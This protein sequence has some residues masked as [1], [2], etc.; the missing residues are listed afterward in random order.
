MP[1]QPSK[2][3]PDDNGSKN[4]T[5]GV[6][7]GPLSKQ[8]KIETTVEIEAGHVHTWRN[9]IALSIMV[10]GIIAL[11]I[12]CT[13]T[14][15]VHICIFHPC[16]NIRKPSWTQIINATMTPNLQAEI[17]KSD[18][19]GLTVALGKTNSPIVSGFFCL[20]TET[21]SDEGLPHTLEHLI[22]MGSTTFPYKGVLDLMANRC[23]A[24]RTNA[25]TGS[26]HTC[27]TVST[28]GSNGFMKI[29]PVF[30][31]HIL[32]PTLREG[33]YRTQVHSINGDGQD[34]GVVYGE[35][36]GIENTPERSLLRKTLELLYTETSGYRRETG[37]ILANIRTEATNE[38]VKEYHKKYYRPENLFLTITGKVEEQQIFDALRSVE[39]KWMSK[40][41]PGTPKFQKPWQNL[42]PILPSNE[43]TY[44]YGSTDETSGYVLLAWR[45]S[46]PITGDSKD[47]LAQKYL[48]DFLT[49]PEIG[50]LN[51]AIVSTNEP[52][53]T[54]IEVEQEN[55]REPVFILKFSNV[56]VAN[57]SDIAPQVDVIIKQIIRDTKIFKEI[58]LPMIHS[59]IDQD[60]LR[61]K[62]DKE[63]IPQTFLP[64][65]TCIFQ[66]YGET[67]EDFNNL[68]GRE[69]RVP[70]LRKETTEFWIRALNHSLIHS[71]KIVLRGEPSAK[72]VKE[73][74]KM[75]KKRIEVRNKS[76]N[77]KQ[78]KREEEEG[79]QNQKSPP[80]QVLLEVPL[81]DVNQISFRNVKINNYLTKL[82]T[83]PYDVSI[84]NV[85]SS[86]VQLYI[87]MDTR[88]LTQRQKTML[89]LLLDLWTYAGV[90]KDGSI[91]PQEEVLRNRDRNILGF[92]ADLGLYEEY[93]EAIVFEAQCQLKNLDPALDSIRDTLLFAD[94]TEEEV[95]ISIEN[96][97]HSLPELKQSPSE[98]K[99]AAYN[100][101][102]FKRDSNRYLRTLFKQEPF[103]KNLTKTNHTSTVKD[104][105]E[106]MRTITYSNNGFVYIA[107]EAHKLI[108]DHDG[109]LRKLSNLFK[110]TSSRAKDTSPKIKYD[111]DLMS[112]LS[113]DL[114]HI[115]IGIPETESCYLRRIVDIKG[116]SLTNKEIAEMEVLLRYLS[117]RMY[118]QIRGGGL[119]YGADLSLSLPKGHISLDLS[120][121][122]Q[123]INAISLIQSLFANYSRDT[124]T[125]DGNLIDSAK[126]SIIFEKTRNE[127]TIEDM[128]IEVTK[129]LIRSN[130]KY[131][132][133][134][135]IAKIAEVSSKD[136]SKI[137]KEYLPKFL[138]SRDSVSILICNS[139]RLD[140]IVKQ[141]EGIQTA[142]QGKDVISFNTFST[143]SEFGE[144]PRLL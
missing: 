66:L 116:N 70:E 22:F 40:T 39:Q 64:Q 113:E 110:V 30:M 26:D 44:Q 125:W 62:K 131:H 82:A 6:I 49:L 33:D 94:P 81:A 61:V 3:D 85:N 15:Q 41:D 73:R 96:K 123:V 68:M 54:S 141:L 112:E 20:A 46:A 48:L 83:F 7:K 74:I 142:I 99:Y 35:M 75:E 8:V 71:P 88:K 57:L 37:G 11:G 128:I 133:R 16:P 140:T 52:M 23:F 104:L 121:S 137:A 117:D 98:V 36:Q 105:K 79:L 138:N 127:E 95:K 43:T 126:G 34:V 9:K 38:R 124:T 21:H 50:P 5:R 89:P 143:V 90:S 19:T 80:A 130:H 103:L 47:L 24:D 2:R 109:A 18:S 27:F 119:A 134:N 115:A 91:I 93:S 114:R 107:T 78:L 101:L 53:A 13:Y 31:D 87:F 129:A 111:K 14:L 108:N 56:P 118:E 29:L 102:V 32:H 4:S 86:F 63:N 42:S 28:A 1:H 97:L 67:R 139:A 72:L 92:Y 100:A 76:L 77:F 84:I 135:L 60:L 136:L 65:I 17:Y 120:R 12:A 122:P 106:I 51:Q 132:N 69:L 10:V 59:V 55:F 45:R 144:D 25:W 58:Y